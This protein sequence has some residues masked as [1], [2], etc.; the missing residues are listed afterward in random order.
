MSALPTRGLDAFPEGGREKQEVNSR[1]ASR[2]QE[3]QETLGRP[4]LLA[5]VSAGSRG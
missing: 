2:R 4:S 5:V 1:V 3:F